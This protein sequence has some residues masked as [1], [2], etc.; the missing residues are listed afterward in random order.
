M[1]AFMNA[2]AILM[3]PILLAIAVIYAYGFII[4]LSPARRMRDAIMGF[5]FG[6]GALFAMMTPMVFADGVIVDM[7][8]LI[9]AISAAFFGVFGALI[10]GAI[11][12]ATRIYIGGGGALAGT[13][14]ICLAATA[15]LIWAN[16][17]RN[18]LGNATKEHLILGLMA[19]AHLLGIA[20]LPSGIA[21]Q[22]LTEMA[23]I[24]FIF[25]VLG[26]LLIGCLLNREE[27]LFAE[28]E[29]LFDAATTDPLTRLH[30]RRSAVAAYEQLPIP[31]ILNHGTAMLC[32]DVDNFKAVNDSHG[33]IFGDAVLAEISSRI[34]GIL[35]PSDVFSRLGGDEFL[36]ILPSVTHHETQNIA[37]RCREV[38]AQS[39]M[40]DSSTRVPVT[41]SVG[42]E[43]L[44]DR[45]DFLTFVARADAA[46]YEAK[47][48]G[49]NCVAFAW[50]NAALA[51][52]T[53][54][55]STMIR[56]A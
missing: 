56:T 54:S 45:P 27:G 44:P 32:F 22:L 10:A 26:A 18:K 8:N 35:R 30:N 40:V 6:L 38:I 33:H 19:S 13:V 24:L 15:G 42:A 5:V 49:R 43:W 1:L 4:R 47:R 52:Q 41:I 28:N 11:G 31:K 16:Y 21:W 14:G 7:R 20:V 51:A 2:A 34:S 37:E 3:D 23:P 12:I 29:A 53:L 39:A 25:N 17:V 48:L 50:D 55:P 46:L 36:I 9:I